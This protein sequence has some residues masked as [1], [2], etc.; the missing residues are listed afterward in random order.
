MKIKTNMKSNE[1]KSKKPNNPKYLAI[2]SFIYFALALVTG[3]IALK[4]IGL[5]TDSAPQYMYALVVLYS[6]AGFFI[7]YN[8]LKGKMWALISLVLI[9]LL[10]IVA[11]IFL[12]LNTN[13]FR[14]PVIVYLLLAFALGSFKHMKN[15]KAKQ[16]NKSN[17][18]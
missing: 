4:R 15:T 11:R 10:E 6:V 18:K 3:I 5:I 9:L 2:F 17:E 13:L 16:K 1:T 8:I 12:A 7:S 14:M